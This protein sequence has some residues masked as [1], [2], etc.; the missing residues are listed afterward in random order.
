MK[1]RVGILLAFASILAAASGCKGGDDGPIKVEGG[2]NSGGTA[3][4][5]GQV[6]EGSGTANLGKATA[7]PVPGK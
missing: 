4:G 2:Y 3:G 6:A 7:P 5:N 1:T